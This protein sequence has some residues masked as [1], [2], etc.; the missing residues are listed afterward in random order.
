MIAL[1]ELGQATA[2]CSEAR[3]SAS[4][5]SSGVRAIRVLAATP[6]LRRQFPLR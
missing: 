3:Q 1:P 6:M 5:S 2:A 4:A